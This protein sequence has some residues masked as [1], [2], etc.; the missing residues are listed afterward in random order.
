MRQRPTPQLVLGSFVRLVPGG[1]V[2]RV[3]WRGKQTQPA[4]SDWPGTMAVYRLDDGFWDCYYE[5]QLHVARPW[6][7]SPAGTEPGS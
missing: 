7:S 1:P 4:H 6:N 5:Y 3:I 2:Y